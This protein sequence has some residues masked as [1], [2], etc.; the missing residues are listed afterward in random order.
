VTVWSAG[1]STRSCRRDYELTPLGVTLH[2]TIQSLVTWTE[3][4]QSEIATAR[5]RYDVLSS[6]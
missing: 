2:A 5:A 4:H 3:T 1:P 6:S